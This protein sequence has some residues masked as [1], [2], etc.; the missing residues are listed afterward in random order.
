MHVVMLKFCKR[1]DKESERYAD[2]RCKFCAK[3]HYA[4]WAAENRER[5]NADSLRWNAANRSKKLA[6]AAVYRANNRD[7]INARRREIRKFDP[8]QERIKASKRRTQKRSGGGKLS[9]N[10]VQSLLNLQ[11]GLCACCG[12]ALNG[13]FH[14]DHKVP[15]SRGGSNTDDNVQLLHPTCNLRKYTMTHEEFLAQLKPLALPAS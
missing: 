15:L 11:Q 7:T 9:K 5:R 1:C 6:T 8:S 3:A 2:G 14:L 4:R 13:V 10:I 12:A